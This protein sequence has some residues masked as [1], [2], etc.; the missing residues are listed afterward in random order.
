MVNGTTGSM[1]PDVTTDPNCGPLNVLAKYIYN[2]G[3]ELGTTYTAAGSSA[4]IDSAVSYLNHH[5]YYA[6]SGYINNCTN[7]LSMIKDRNNPILISGD[8]V[9]LAHGHA[10]LLDGVASYRTSKRIFHGNHHYDT[11]CEHRYDDLVHC[12]FGWNG[13]CDGYYVYKMFDPT[14]DPIYREYG[15]QIGTNYCA[16]LENMR[17]IVF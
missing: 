15:D 13:N 10:W 2:I 3:C 8:N 14:V 5:G 7:L 11:E 4:P 12:N 9:R 17:V 6:M 1:F 16:Y